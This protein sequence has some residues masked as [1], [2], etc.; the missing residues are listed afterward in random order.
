MVVR[1]F[2]K[3]IKVEDAQSPYDTIH[4]KVFYPGDDSDTQNPFFNT[5]AAKD[6]APFPIVI[7]FSGFNCSLAMYQW[8]AMKLAER[9][10]VV[11]LFDWLV[12]TADRDPLLSPGVNLAA[13][14]SET[15][16]TVPSASALPLLLKELDNL[17]LVGVLAGM[18]DLQKIILGGHS[19]GGRLA[20]ENAEPK[21]F[22]RVAGA[23]SYGAHS[24]APTSLG[25]EPGTVLPLPDSLPMLLIGGTEDGVIASNSTIYGV[26]KW[27]TSAT[28]IIRT[29]REAIDRERGDSCL[30]IVEGANHFAIAER[31]DPTLSVAAKDFPATQSESKIRFL[32][33]SII[34][35]F[36]DKFILDRP[37]KLQFELLLQ[38][39][40]LIALTEFKRS[41]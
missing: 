41:T 27:S 17:Q 6:L 7:F 11:V 28:P 34:G 16:G 37:Q 12:K 10:L 30:V 1:A 21:F 19:A 5:P 23:F 22:D 26:E 29:F 8:L 40:N 14:S 18:L 2:W 9:G 38:T 35:L 39:H 31:A 25:Y 24:A 13:F 4:L 33:T 36:I 20:L 32:L 15:Y 3:A